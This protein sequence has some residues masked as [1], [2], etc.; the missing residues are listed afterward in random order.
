MKKSKK[1]S[2]FNFEDKEH[3]RSLV[4][5]IDGYLY[6]VIYKD[7]EAVASYH[8]PQCES[9][10]GY[11]PEDYNRDPE[12]WIKMVATEDRQRIF[13][14]FN[15]R[16]V[17]AEQTYIEHRIIRKDGKKRWIANRFTEQ[18]DKHGIL[19]RRDGFVL[20]ITEKKHA[21]LALEEQFL[22]LQ[23]LIDAIP[24]PVFYKDING[25]YKGCNTAF[26][27]YIGM[28]R[29]K[30]IGYDVRNIMTGELADLHERMDNNVKDNGVL[31]VYESDFLHAEGTM[32]KIIYYKGPYLNAKGV[33]SG[34]VGIMI[35][36]T[37]LKVA[38]ETLQ[39]TFLK[40]KEMES[41]VTKS[42]A[43]V[44]MRAAE[45]K[46]P[47]EYV[48]DNIEHFG[49]SMRD[50]VGGKLKFFDI[51]LPEDR[52]R[53]AKEIKLNSGKSLDDFSL[54]YR[55]V[56]KTGSI[57]WVDDHTSI[58]CDRWG[59][60]THYLGIIVDITKRKKAI[61]LSRES[62]ERYKT[63]AENSYDLI[64]E[65]DSKG[66]FSYVS[67]NYKTTLG[68]EDSELIG[69]SLLSYIHPDENNFIKIELKKMSGQVT[70][71]LQHKNGEW[72]WFESAGRQYLTADGD[73]RGVIVSRDISFRKKLQQQLIRSEKL[74]AVGE[75]SAMIAHEFRNSLTSIKMIL[76]LQKESSR[77]QVREKRSLKIALESIQH[78]EEVIKQ[79]L[80]FAQPATMLFKKENLNKAILDSISFAQMHANK[81]EVKIVTKM[82]LKLP[83]VNIHSAS[84]RE[85]LINLLLNA[86]Q[87][88]DSKSIKLN[89]KITITTKRVRLEEQL[90]DKELSVESNEYF[91]VKGGGASQQEF[92]LES[93]TECIQIKIADN[94][95]GIE[96]SHLRHI[97]EP[98]FTS[99]AKGTGLGLP[100][101]KRTINTHG[102]VIR[103][104]SKVDKGTAFII[105]LPI[106]ELTKENV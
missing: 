73:R 4:H 95:C 34:I 1:S 53:V 80:T 71:R 44:F 91:R 35:D 33:I 18:V 13:R 66:K 97:F 8:S 52:E 81:K 105:Y 7:G 2:P 37:Q 102:G 88:F 74:L 40:L 12:L 46:F 94:G 60:I 106:V 17:R 62:A 29:D 36:S 10:M 90:T 86:T 20:D 27:R 11:T 25:K 92:S 70:H 64:C 87:A 41:I 6:T 78:M 23:H 15:A 54:E 103:V 38:E 16:K 48:S 85:C 58:R 5:N 79:L 57:I 98:F 3:F 24:N 19:T 89:R 21:E 9:I 67:P 104:E 43:V 56:S 22:F 101:A 30:I 77:L 45:G 84:F 82:D 61:Q 83:E 59:K 99:K 32:R 72:L 69:T 68:Y 47:I 63:L 14:F 76:Q 49:Y 51:I 31:Q 75:M 28:K 42:P 96:E 65:L 39:E 26:E 100:I 55:I 93:G 50:F